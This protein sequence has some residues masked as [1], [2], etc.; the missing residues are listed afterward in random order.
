MRNLTAQG[1]RSDRLTRAGWTTAIVMAMILGGGAGTV[2]AQ[3][4]SAPVPSAQQLV[5]WRDNPETQWVATTRL[6]QAPQA[7]RY[8]GA[9]EGSERRKSMA[10]QSRSGIPAAARR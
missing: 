8:R 9:G 10:S 1:I 3:D 4:P 5:D 2:T 7:A 6:Q